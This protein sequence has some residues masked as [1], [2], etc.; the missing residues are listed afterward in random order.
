MNH[1]NNV[2]YAWTNENWKKSREREKEK[3]ESAAI[4][5]VRFGLL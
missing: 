5:L 1:T 4:M 3:V 2:M